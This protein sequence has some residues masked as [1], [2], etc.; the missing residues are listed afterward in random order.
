VSYG[1]KVKLLEGYEFSKVDLFNSYIDH[2]YNIKSTSSGAAKFI[3]KLLLN[4]L[5]GVFGRKQE[6]I[7]TI[8]IHPSELGNYAR[9]YTIKNCMNIS[10]NVT[11]ILITQDKDFDTLREVGNTPL[12]S[13]SFK[14]Y[15]VKSNVAIASAVTSYARIHMSQFKNNP[16]FELFY[17]DT[18]SIFVDR[19]LPQ[20]MVGKDLGLMK[21]ELSGGVIKEA[22]FLGIKQYGYWYLD[23]GNNRKISLRRCN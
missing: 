23:S 16:N 1:Y 4:S 14:S 17:T 9:K 20:D 5:Y 2:F 3:A 18:D 6:L 22:Y 10:E 7:Q 15:E 21:D 19:E 13:V 11:T 8:N 12:T